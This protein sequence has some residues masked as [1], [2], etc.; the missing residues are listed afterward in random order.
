MR[1]KALRDAASSGAG[2]AF[3]DATGDAASVY[4]RLGFEVAGRLT[5]YSR[6]A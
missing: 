4:M 3:F 1:V 6:A 5:R 2:R